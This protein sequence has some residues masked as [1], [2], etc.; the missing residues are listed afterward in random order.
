MAEAQSSSKRLA[1]NTLVLYFRTLVIMFIGLYTSRVL[2]EALGIDNYGIYNVIGGFVGMFAVITGTLVATTQ[3]YLNVEIGKGDEGDPKKIF[4]V[5]FG[6]HF[7][8]AVTMILLFET[9]GLWFLNNKLNIPPDRIFAANWVYQLSVLSAVLSLFSTPYIG[10]IV[11]YERMK[12]FAFISLQDAILKLVICYLLYV[13]PYDRLIVYA[14]LFWAILMWNQCI[15]VYYSRRNFK[16]ARIS[17]VREK[18]L[19]RSMFGFAGMNFIGSFSYI[20]S[21]QGVNV[22]L[23]MFFGVAINAARGVAIQVQNAIGRFTSDFMTALN[24]QITK[25]YAAGNHE[26]SV[27]LCL[28]GAKFSYYIMLL[29]TIPIIVRAHDILSLWL[30]VYPEYSVVF[31]RYTLWIALVGV[32]SQPFVTELLATG[33]LKKTTWWIGGTRLLV[34]PLIYVCFKI[35]D[36]PVYAYIV[37]LAMDSLLFFVRLKILSDL[38][39]LPILTLFVKNVLIGIV[40]ITLV[41]LLVSSV[42]HFVLPHSVLNLLIFCIISVISTTIL[43]YFLGLQREERNTINKFIM[44]KLNLYKSK[45]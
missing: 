9:V 28:R 36:S 7:L 45:N 29:F 15:Y 5:I 27:Q 38:I 12:A 32:L 11:A 34:L 26:K 44:S 19:Y 1:R 37:V 4:G 14:S 16:E 22:I 6:I 41:S 25:E 8:L 10:L 30:K 13:I 43:V 33:Q 24:P 42:L 3:R 23:N 2:L 20:L 21:T 39:K 35:W 17:I 40:P 18:E 31:L